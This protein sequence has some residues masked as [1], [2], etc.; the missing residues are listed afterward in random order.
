[1][2]NLTN[3]N[4]V[5]IVPHIQ[6]NSDSPSQDLEYFKKL[7]F[8]GSIK[9]STELIECI[10]NNNLGKTVGQQQKI[11]SEI[12]ASLDSQEDTQSINL[13]ETIVKPAY[14]QQIAYS[15][16]FND[17]Y[18]S[19]FGLSDNNVEIDDNLFS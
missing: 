15:W 16:V 17:F 10:K 1:M 13:L 4:Q 7:L 18:L 19:A 8:D 14:L 12:Y 2:I 6:G 3:T 11:I 5:S 9:S